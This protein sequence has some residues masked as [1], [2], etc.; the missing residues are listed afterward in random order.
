MYHPPILLPFIRMLSASS[1]A[2]LA[3]RLSEPRLPSV[4]PSTIDPIYTA[5]WCFF[6]PQKG[7][8]EGSAWTAAPTS[9]WAQEDVGQGLAAARTG[10]PGPHQAFSVP[11]ATVGAVGEPGLL[12]RTWCQRGLRGCLREEGEQ[13]LHFRFDSIPS[14]TKY[15][16][17]KTKTKPFF[18]RTDG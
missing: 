4:W 13:I 8:R 6:L 2:W 11:F 18:Y 14:G 16:Y 3:C 10:H 9:V 15:I 1:C 12:S 17:L 7:K 5:G